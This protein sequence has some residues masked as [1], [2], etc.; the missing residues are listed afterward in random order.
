MILVDASVAAKWLLPEKG[1]EQAIA[2]ISG[3]ELLFAPA[4][5]RLEVLGAVT[6]G[7][8]MGRAAVEEARD[9]CRK[10]FGYL[11]QGA[12]TLTPEAALIDDA[13][14]L[15]LAIK[16]PIADCMYM[17]AAKMHS[18]RLV[19]ADRALFE[20][21]QALSIEARLLGEDWTN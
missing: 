1:S 17:A 9:R 7:A 11:E 13:V 18:A 5:I 8:R 6:R 21:S 20:K 2:L 14:E 19:T 3:P 12:I 16:H 15:A 10:W 4:I